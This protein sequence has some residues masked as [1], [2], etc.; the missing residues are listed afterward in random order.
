MHTGDVLSS[1]SA[2]IYPLLMERLKNEITRVQSIKAIG[3]I[4]RSK[5]DLDMSLILEECTVLLADLLRQQSRALKQATLDTLNDLVVH[6]GKQM[7]QDLLCEVAAEASSLLVD[8]DLQLCRLGIHLVSNVLVVCP[9]VAATDAILGKCQPNALAL[10][11]SSMLQGPTLE[12]LK[13][14]FAQLTKLSS[15]GSGFAELFASLMVPQAESSKHSVLNVARCVAAICVAT[16]NDGDRQA[17]FAKFIGD[18]KQQSET[19]KSATVLSLYCLGEFG[20]HVSLSAHA[21]V[22]DIVL[23]C[24]TGSPEEV[25]TAAAYALGSICVGN[26]IMYLETVIVKL[27]QGENS[28]LLL[29]S[30]R[31]VIVD[32]AASSS[33]GFAQYVDRVLPVLRKLSEREEE[34]VRNMVAECLG[35]LA[36]TDGDKL[37]PIITELCASSVIGTRWTAVT[38]LKYALTT[39]S[40]ASSS[41]TSSALFANIAPFLAALEDEDL[42]VRRAA[43]LVVN[44]AAHHHAVYLAPYVRER[45]FP[46]LLTTT[47]VKLER[48]VDLGPFKHKVDDGL[49]L[50]KAAYA[51]VDT[52]LDVLPQQVDIALLLPHLQRGLRDQDDIQLLSHQ[53]LI[54]ICR[55]QPGS[56][57][58]AL[59]VLLEPLDKTLNKKVK[60]DQVGPEV[61]RVKDLIRSALRAVDAIS[62]VRDAEAHPKFAAM[63]ENIKRNKTLAPLLENVKSEHASA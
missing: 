47:E 35:K 44:T 23:Q 13:V 29:S 46:V 25:K 9:A 19:D 18:I 40:V 30:L 10:S 27:E 42:S 5:L 33:R 20:R 12:A 52:L 17:A 7:K 37:M 24:F 58:G 14:F 4:A 54:K 45:V 60:E 36:V 48:V 22:K 8:V 57:V 61:E 2:E 28:Y 63:L 43:L 51:C 31:E 38:S 1:R 53:I 32:H 26:M 3:V 55:V 39:T 49:P 50:R 59:D 21:D 34:G 6:K 15:P 41:S 11:H 56:V 16:T 62:G